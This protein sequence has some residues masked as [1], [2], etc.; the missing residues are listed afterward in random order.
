MY[1]VLNGIKS[2]SIIVIPLVNIKWPIAVKS[3]IADIAIRPDN[4]KLCL[5]VASLITKTAI[6]KTTS[7]T[8]SGFIFCKISGYC[9]V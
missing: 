4:G 6:P 2:G 8:I 1:H 9:P 7:K 5:D 3:S